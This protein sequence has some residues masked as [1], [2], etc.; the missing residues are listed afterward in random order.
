M[1]QRAGSLIN[2]IDKCLVQLTKEK[3]QMIN[4]RNETG[5]YHYQS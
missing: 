1:K 5:G 4:I 2:K 3:T